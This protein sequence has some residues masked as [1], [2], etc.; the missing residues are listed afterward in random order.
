MSYNA[1]TLYVTKDSFF[2]FSGIDLDIEL[3]NAN[4][5]NDTLKANI[6]LRQQQKWLYD[7]MFYRFDT[8]KWDDEWDDALFTEALKWQ[9]KRVLKYGEDD[10]LD[11][12]AYRVLRQGAMANRKK[13]GL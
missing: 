6:F 7:Y 10:M 12:T 9:I 2:E 4:Y 8:S 11:P 5:D 3:D 13:I 1:T